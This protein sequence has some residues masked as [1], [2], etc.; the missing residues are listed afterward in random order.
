MVLD[1]RVVGQV[2]GGEGGPDTVGLAH[3]VAAPLALAAVGAVALAVGA[4]VPRVTPGQ[5]EG[6]EEMGTRED[7]CSQQSSSACQMPPGRWKSEAV[8]GATLQPVLALV[9]SAAQ[10]LA[11]RGQ[12]ELAC[13][14]SS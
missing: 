13:S 11:L 7:L 6:Q 12:T 5:Q 2:G 1:V 14:A 9:V 4:Q 3:V 10:T 8:V